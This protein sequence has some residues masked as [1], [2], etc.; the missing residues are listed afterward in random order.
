MSVFKN[1]M[2]AALFLSLSAGSFAAD[3]AKAKDL[4][5]AYYQHS[6]ALEYAELSPLFQPEA[7]IDITWKYGAGH[8]DDE[9]STTVAELDKYLDEETIRKSSEMMASYKEL[10]AKEEI[11]SVNEDKDEILVEAVQTVSYE[12]EGYQ[13]TSKQTDLFVLKQVDGQLKIT[14]MESVLEF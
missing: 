12:I 1:L 6:N 4:V 9:V 3:S 10:T 14:E 2:N 11:T 5:L 13:G 8:P 7:K